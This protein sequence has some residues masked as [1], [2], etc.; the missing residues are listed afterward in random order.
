[1]RPLAAKTWWWLPTAVALGI[2]AWLDEGQSGWGYAAGWTAVGIVAAV[3][4]VFAR[5]ALGEG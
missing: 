1:M 4:A 3:V 5:Q 2:L